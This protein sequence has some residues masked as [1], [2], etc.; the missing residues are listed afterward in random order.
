M[1]NWDMP[2]HNLFPITS[3]V[4]WEIAGFDDLTGKKRPLIDP[5]LISFRAEKRG[6]LGV[7]FD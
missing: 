6:S 5:S 4:W 1:N 3:E 2:S 7:L